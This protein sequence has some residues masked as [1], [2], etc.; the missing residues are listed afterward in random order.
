MCNETLRKIVSNGQQNVPVLCISVFSLRTDKSRTVDDI[1][2]EVEEL[3]T[4]T[5]EEPRGFALHR[6]P[7]AEKCG[8]G[9]GTA[10]FIQS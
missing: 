9:E 8:S 1:I 7:V 6:T 10:V 5:D 2:R 3:R 4:N